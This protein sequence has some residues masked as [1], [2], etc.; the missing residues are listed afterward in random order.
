MTPLT[1]LS[2][3]EKNRK[4]SLLG[5][6]EKFSTT[7]WASWLW[8]SISRG[9]SSTTRLAHHTGQLMRT[10]W[11]AFV[12]TKRSAWWTRN[13]TVARV[14]K[15]S[16]KG[17]P[18]RGDRCPQEDGIIPLESVAN[19]LLKCP[20]LT[21]LYCYVARYTLVY[22]IHRKNSATWKCNQWKVRKLYGSQSGDVFEKSRQRL[23]P[24]ACYQS[25]ANTEKYYKWNIVACG[26]C[27]KQRTTLKSVLT[28]DFIFTP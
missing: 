7:R 24:G 23:Y 13:I 10:S 16:A 9:N 17:V 1:K 2:R 14:A 18:E 12:A 19:A 27:N 8:S 26:T 4:V 11:I 25:Y 6:L 21:E 22:Y 20:K 15:A 3:L 5:K 28:S